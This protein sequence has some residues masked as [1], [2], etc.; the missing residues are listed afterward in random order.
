[1][2]S[3]VEDIF[4]VKYWVTGKYLQMVLFQSN[5]MF[6]PETRT[7]CYK[8]T[9]RTRCLRGCIGVMEAQRAKHVYSVMSVIPL[10]ACLAVQGGRY[11]PSRFV[12]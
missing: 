7:S 8:Q 10:A 11:D 4:K 6:T 1:M 12:S 2:I 9:C 3:E 5:D